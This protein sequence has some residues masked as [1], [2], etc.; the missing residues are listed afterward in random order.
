MFFLRRVFTDPKRTG[1]FLNDVE[2]AYSISLRWFQNEYLIGLLPPISPQVDFLTLRLEDFFYLKMFFAEEFFCNI[3]LSDSKSTF[4]LF[5]FEENLTAGGFA[6]VM[7]FQGRDVC[8]PSLTF[9]CF[10]RWH[11]YEM[12]LKR[13]LFFLKKTQ[14]NTN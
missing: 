11:Q 9:I 1:V 5:N 4:F 10:V 12:S 6:V 7:S 2:G 3:F 8:T 13:R 14:K